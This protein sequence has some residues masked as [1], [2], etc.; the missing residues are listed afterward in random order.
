MYFTYYKRGNYYTGWILYK[1][2]DV[3]IQIYFS[4]KSKHECK[5]FVYVTTNNNGVAKDGEELYYET[6]LTLKK[7]ES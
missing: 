4:E 6:S 2:S 5:M 3:L 1:L 7:K